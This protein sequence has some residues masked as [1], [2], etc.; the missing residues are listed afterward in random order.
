MEKNEKEK[1][2]GLLF[3]VIIVASLS[4][5]VIPSIAANISKPNLV[6]DA[7][8]EIWDLCNKTYHV[9]YTI[10]NTGT[11]NVSAGHYTA[12]YVNGAR[13]ELHLVTDELVTNIGRI[14]TFTT[15]IECTP[16]CDTIKVCADYYNIV[17]ESNETDNCRENN[18]TCKPDL[19]IEKNVSWKTCNKSYTVNYTISNKGNATALKG[20]TTT[21]YVDGNVI[22]RMTVPVDL[23]PCENKTYTFQSQIECTPPFENVTVCADEFDNINEL[24]ETNNCVTNN[25]TCKPDLVVD[26]EVVW[27]PCNKRYTI[28]Y[29][30]KNI[31]N[32]TAPSGHNTT[33]FVDGNLIENMTVPNAL[34]P[35]DKYTATF[36]TA[37]NCTPDFDNV[38]VCADYNE[39]VAELNETNNCVT[40]IFTCKP[41]LVIVNKWEDWEP[42]TGNYTV[43]YTIK[44]IGNATA[45]AC[46]NTSLHCDGGV[47]ICIDHVPLNL[48]PC[49]TYT[50]TFNCTISCTRPMDN[51]SVKAD[52]NGTIQELNESNNWYNNTWTCKPDLIIKDKWEKEVNETHY[53]VTYVIENIGNATAPP[54]HNTTLFVDGNLIENMTMPNALKPCDKYTATFTTAINCT[55]DF[56]NVTVC[57]DYNNTVPE[58]NEDNNCKKNIWTCI[59]P[60]LVIADKWEKWVNATHYN[61]TYVIKNIG[62]EPAS[63]GHTTALYVDDVRK[64]GQLVDKV[65][66]INVKETYT[67]TTAIECTAPSDKVTVRADDYNAIAELNETNNNRTNI[68]PCKVLKSDLVIANKWEEWVNATHYNVTYVIKNIG[69]AVALAGHNIGGVRA[70]G[71]TTALYVDGD[72]KD[73]QLV[74]DAIDPGTDKTYTFTTLIEYTL[75]CD[76]IKVCADH[77]NLIDELNETN[78]CL[79]NVWKLPD[80]VITEKY[81]TFVDDG[82]F[83][84]TYKVNNIGCADAGASNTTIYIDGVPLKHVPTPAIPK[85]DCHENTVGPFE[86]PCGAILNVT[87]CA[88]NYDEVGESNETNNCKVNEVVCPG[89]PDLVI[90]EK[91]ETFVDDGKFNITYKVNNIGCADA[92]ASN[93]TIYIDGVPLKH[94]P[95]PAIPKGDCHE[96]TV[97]PFECPCG[98]ILNVTVCADN[99]DEVGESNETNNCKVNEVVCP[100]KSDLVIT[101]KWVC[102]P[103]NCTICYNVTNIGDGTAPA[104]HNTTLYVDGVEVAHDHVPVDLAPGESYIGCFDDYTWTYTP[105]SDN[106]TVCADNNE[107]LDELDETNNCLTNI[108]MCGDVNG[109][110]K[111]TMSDV[112]KVFNRYL[113]SSYPLDLPWAA[114]VNCDSK[115][116]MSDVRKVFNRY[117]DPSYDLN[118]CC[119]SK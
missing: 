49:Q 96:N 7:K 86:C 94:V 106:I 51:I 103:D 28:R 113:D 47:P 63:A 105:P 36:T 74:P 99:Y 83:N 59:N 66:G 5:A 50:A 55:P 71:H 110:G 44:N 88:D 14:Y 112:R 65:L 8:E 98:A 118:C 89:K 6:I 58:S 46:H 111:V 108:W 16:S 24:N 45:L 23:K 69:N 62:N 15:A 48:T 91:Y 13:R 39:T 38:T 114:D 73:L 12:L 78:N 97:G 68:L 30:I 61:V 11:A 40:N 107:T 85:G 102:W 72:L 84:I 32:A 100:L 104:C 57:A 4:T 95:T 52:Y 90:T 117:L 35:C 10:N 76:T 26:K 77:Y 29:N 18:L 22:K 19:V 25:F 81:E 109:D 21:L 119:A 115:V 56:D 42:C 70:A 20:H 67:F 34:K 1:I 31:G 60:D 75:P 101:D 41:D 37:I 54:G 53:N 2:I 93:T 87:V 92:G 116:T 33:L 64:E 43:R 27:E 80:L 82:K 79:E 3:I 9:N 17:D